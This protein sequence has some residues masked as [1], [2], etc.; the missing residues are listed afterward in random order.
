M[1]ESLLRGAALGLATGT[2]CLASCGPV[3]VAYLLGEKRSALGSVR[4]IL[5]LNVGRFAAYAA[6]GALAG[7]LGGAVPVVLRIP[8]SAAGYILFAA[9]LVLSSIRVQRS[10]GGCSTNRLLSFTRSAFLLGV[11]TGFSICPAFLIALTGAFDSSGPVGGMLLFMGFYAGTTVYM[12]PFAF[13][14]L[15]TRREWFTKA[16][17]ILSVMVAAYFLAFGIRMLVRHFSPEPISFGGSGTVQDDEIFS[18]VEQDTIYLVTDAGDPADHGIEL[19][20][21]LSDL[22]PEV[23]LLEIDSTIWAGRMETVPPLSGVVAPWWID[24]RSQDRGAGWHLEAASRAEEARLRIFAVEYEPWCSDRAE[25]IKAFMERYS[26]SVAPDS[27]FSFLMLNTLEC[28][29][30]ACDTCPAG[31][32]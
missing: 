20:G 22:G 4:I 7:L 13:L 23:V 15:L 2:T 5:M 12:L 8:L 6:F 14:G 32:F 11:L 10:C 9:Y 21:F 29:P 26:F 31:L 25:A 3:Y 17:R 24:A 16:A 28:D 1:I 19:A 27:G 18:L 30:S